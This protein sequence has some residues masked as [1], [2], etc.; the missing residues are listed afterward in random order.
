MDKQ[1]LFISDKHR[2]FYEE[3]IDRVREKDCYHMALIYTLGMNADCLFSGWQTSGS[4]KVIRMAF[5]L[6]CNSMPSIDCFTGEENK[7]REASLYSVEEL[8]CCSYA[9]FFWQAVQIR[10]PEYRDYNFEFHKSLGQR[11]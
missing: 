3:N 11:D 10:Y 2:L 8:F 7:L 4:M 5:N 9:P 6:Y 1:I